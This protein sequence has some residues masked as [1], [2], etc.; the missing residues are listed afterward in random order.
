MLNFSS[1]NAFNLD[2]S[3]NLLFGNELKLNIKGSDAHNTNITVTKQIITISFV[4][5]QAATL[6]R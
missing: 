2:Q 4:Y 3:K 1:A 5:K 6:V